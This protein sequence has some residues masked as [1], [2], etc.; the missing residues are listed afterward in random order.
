MPGPAFLPAEPHRKI[1][2]PVY[3]VIPAAGSGSR[4]GAGRNKQFLEVGGLPLIIRTL[5]AF[6]QHNEVVGYV[7][8]TAADES[9]AMA[10]LIQRFDLRKLVALADGGE[11]RQASV[12]SGLRR[13]QEMRPDAAA[14]IILV[15]DG[16]R[17]FVTKTILDRCIATIAEKGGACGAA[18][19]VK[20]TIK[21]VRADGMI[22]QTLDRSR[23]W[24]MQTPQGA[25][26]SQL[27]SAYE[28]LEN[29]GRQ[30]TDDLAAMEAVGQPTWLVA[31]DY[32]NIKMTTPEDLV[33]GEAIAGVMR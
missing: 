3:V 26:F 2:M 17:C 14:G 33:I 32:T 25:L 16:A 12:L 10:L 29:N 6:E 15:H 13:L 24:A 21:L 9:E 31:G 20:D 19:P 18:V 1:D 23:L 28:Q 4:M 7:V 5:L 30:V 11:T 22:E 27:L 8:V